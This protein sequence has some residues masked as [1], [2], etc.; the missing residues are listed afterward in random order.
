MKQFLDFASLMVFFIVY[1]L[2][3]I[4]IASYALIAATLLLL[5]FRWVKYRQVDKISLLNFITVLICCTLTL[6]FH[7][8][9]FIK[10][11]VTVIYLLFALILLISQ[12]VLKKS[13]IHYIFS[14]KIA[15]PKK[16]LNK[17][18][19]AWSMF[20]LACS[21]LNIYVAFWKPQSTW[22]NFKVFCL[23]SITMIFAV[24]NG[25]YIYLCIKKEK[26]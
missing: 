17:L 7:N 11:K 23:P 14:K 15:L 2:Y 5:V 19:F 6:I 18:I 12:F 13:I 26:E 24:I 10:W 16:T 1:K 4:Y 21:I 9:V 22:I 20:F 8:D 25:I 3:D